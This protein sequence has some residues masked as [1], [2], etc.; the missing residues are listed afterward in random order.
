VCEAAKRKKEKQ[1]VLVDDAEDSDDAIIDEFL[2]SMNQT[3]VVT[4]LTSALTAEPPSDDGSDPE[5][6]HT[7]DRLTPTLNESRNESDDDGNVVTLFSQFVVYLARCC[8]ARSN[9]HNS[10]WFSYDRVTNPVSMLIS[11][12]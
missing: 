2:P 8:G 12:C 1:L 6:S 3:A 10:V 9:K 7:A 4:A 11:K 5:P